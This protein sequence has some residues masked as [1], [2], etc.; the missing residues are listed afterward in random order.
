MCFCSTSFFQCLR[1][2]KI[3]FVLFY[4]SSSTV[5]IAQTHDN[6]KYYADL[7]VVDENKTLQPS[8]KLAAFY[9]L[10]KILESNNVT[11]DS[12]YCWTIYK[13]GY[14]ESLVNNDNSAALRYTLHS[15]QLNNSNKKVFS[16]NLLIKSF[17]DIA[18]YYYCLRNYSK[19]LTYYDS[20]IQAVKQYGDTTNILSNSIHNRVSLLF[21]SGDY[22]KCIDE[23]IIGI[24]YALKKKDF[25][26]YLFFL[27]QKAQS[28]FF[29]KQFENSLKDLDTIINLCKNGDQWFHLASAL[30]IKGY[31]FAEKDKP[32]EAEKFFEQ[33][34]LNRKQTKD[35]GQIA[36]DYND[37]GNF[38]LNSRKDYTRA[39]N[40][41]YKTISFAKKVNDSLRLARAYVNIGEVNYSLHDLKAAGAYY[42]KALSVLNFKTNNI[43]TNPPATQLGMFGNKELILV[44]MH[45]KLK[46][47]INLFLDC[48]DKKYLQAALKTAYVND[49][50][51]TNLR[52]EQFWEQS[53]LYWREY[54]T[55]FFS[56]A[57]E[58]AFLAN[59]T[60]DAFYFMEKSRAVLLSD[61]LNELKAS[62]YI[63]ATALSQERE[64]LG[65]VIN[66]KQ[67]LFTLAGSNSKEYNEQKLKLLR[68]Q[69][70]YERYIRLLEK[71][72]PLYSH[73]KYSDEIFSIAT[74]QQYIS[75]NKQT[76]VD[77]F[78]GDSVVY[79]LIITA[80]T[81][82]MIR[83]PGKSSVK[84]D[85]SGFIKLCS[86][87]QTLNSNYNLFAATSY[88]LYE[89]LF[90]PLHINK[91]R[92]IICFDNFL[93]PFEALCKDV[94]GKQFLIN[95]FIFSYVYS[96]RYLLKSIQSKP[97]KGSFIGF[98]P[99][100][101]QPSFNLNRL[102]QSEEVLR[103]SGQLF[104]DSKT[105]TNSKATKENFINNFSNYA[106]VNVFSHARADSGDTE[107]I[108]FMQDSAIH[109]S[110]L[111]LV[112]NVS[113][114]LVVLSACETNVGKN[115]TGEGIYSFARGFAYAGIPSVAATLWKADETTI[116]A[117]SK[118]FH[119]YIAKGLCADEALQKAKLDFM[120][121][122]NEKLL[123]YYWANMVLMGKTESLK[124][125]TAFSHGIIILQTAIILLMVLAIIV[126]IKRTR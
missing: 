10:K 3:L 101:F 70:Q 96:A 68:E 107:P 46:L 40:C 18:Y 44:I 98:A 75:K 21:Q 119:E 5:T 102:S 84:T 120:Q 83:L 8:S 4:C 30:K 82:K 125:T 116:Y 20:T 99:V 41:Y 26:S 33:A 97:A 66:T 73:Y 39:K 87:Q 106:I 1:F 32:A 37:F 113:T 9:N 100:S 110:E 16:K 27:N 90:Q 86:D 123:P 47:M 49:S 45:N 11:E 95:D 124:L 43:L 117:I 80:D 81:T 126:L 42:I 58:A 76:F 71:N 56:H 104:A 48:K 61:K 28:L 109:L 60:A 15:L 114:K 25:S 78:L 23:S 7:I 112:K 93:L 50:L 38:Y 55:S 89:T 59:N 69:E 36:G 62:G 121:K 85:I 118:T 103:Q 111:E 65:M 63:P 12:I 77:Y 6:T 52:Y 57:M 64:L 54:T 24:E 17:Y 72:Y 92:I 122:G 108:L 29:E 22:N 91:G 35:Y 51:V 105:F 53:K 14:Y 13:I 2:L 34:I 19:S 79:V 67:T 88:K 74:V 115:A 31:I 94:Q